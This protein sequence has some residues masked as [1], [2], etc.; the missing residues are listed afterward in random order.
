YPASSRDVLSYAAPDLTTALDVVRAAFDQGLE[1]RAAEILSPAPDRT[2]GRKRV[3]LDDASPFLVLIEPWGP[4]AGR[5]NDWVDSLFTGRL[6]R[7]EPP[8]GWD[9]HEG[10][11]PPPRAWTAP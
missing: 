2:W 11:L 10:L 5:S 1:P 8:V 6:R 7:L 9:V 4:L 3:G